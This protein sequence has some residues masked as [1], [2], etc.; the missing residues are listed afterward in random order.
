VRVRACAA[1]TLVFVAVVALVAS[2]GRSRVT[3]GPNPPPT[4]STTNGIKTVTIDSGPSDVI[5]TPDVA[6]Y[7]VAQACADDHDVVRLD[8]RE[9][10]IH[11]VHVFDCATARHSKALDAAQLVALVADR[12]DATRRTDRINSVARQLGVHPYSRDDMVWL[13]GTGIEGCRPLRGADFYRQE[14]ESAGR[15]SNHE[16]PEHWTKVEVARL[17][18][19][20][21]TQIAAFLDTIRRAGQPDAAAVVRAD[22][23]RIDALKH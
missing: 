4:P 14:I 5:T 8:L 20:C 6:L 18:G 12:H 11:L 21:P 16:N 9:G 15:G 7:E 23:A 10:D 19:T 17:V 13:I 22:L 2:C 1:K 3:V